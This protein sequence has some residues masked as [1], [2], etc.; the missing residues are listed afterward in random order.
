[1]LWWDTRKLSEPTDELVLNESP[2]RVLGGSSMEYNIE[3]GPAKYLVGTEQGVVLSMNMKKAK[4][5]GG[6]KKPSDNAGVISVMDTGAGKHHGPIYS[7]HRNPFWP[8][9]Y[10][11]VGDWSVRVWSEKNKAPIMVR[12]HARVPRASF[13]S[14]LS[15]THTHTFES[16]GFSVQ[17]GI[18]D[19]WRV[20][21]DPRWCFLRDAK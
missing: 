20:V 19:G 10:M 17:Q 21:V 15:L 14:S 5:G 9:N 13:F 7:V 12:V 11:T 1:M 8:T 16:A 18:L 2:T 6:D 4:A 3:A